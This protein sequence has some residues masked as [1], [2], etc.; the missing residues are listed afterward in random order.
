M[1]SVK[2]FCHFAIVPLFL[3]ASTTLSVQT[4]QNAGYDP[5]RDPEQDLRS[6]IVDAQENGKR[7]ILVIGG[8]WCVWCHVLNRF[9]SENEDIENL[10]SNNYLTVKVNVSPENVNEEFL[11]RYPKV[12]GYPH[13][14]VLEKDGSLLHSQNTGKL[15]TGNTYSKR[16]V[17]GFLKE[18]A[19]KQG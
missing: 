17:R 6:A 4:T 3:L 11:S 18:W 13:F 12:A 14:F 1:M 19:P 2:V 16:K 8:E 15:E 10:W 9:L 7:I 5:L